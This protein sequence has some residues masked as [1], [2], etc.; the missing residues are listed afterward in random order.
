M[1][2]SGLVIDG[3]HIRTNQGAGNL[4]ATYLRVVNAR[5]ADCRGSR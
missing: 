2:Q 1:I 5:R 3:V 4:V